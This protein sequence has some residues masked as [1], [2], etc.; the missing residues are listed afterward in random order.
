MIGGDSGGWSRLGDG[1]A[2]MFGGGG[3]GDGDDGGG[4]WWRRW[5]VVVTLFIDKLHLKAY[6]DKGL[7]LTPKTGLE[8]KLQLNHIFVFDRQDIDWTMKWVK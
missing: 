2:V 6:N 3:G 5:L 1:G 7:I 4:S 8:L